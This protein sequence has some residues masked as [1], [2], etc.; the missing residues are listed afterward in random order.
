MAVPRWS[1]SPVGNGTWVTSGPATDLFLLAKPEKPASLRGAAGRGAFSAS[2]SGGKRDLYPQSRT[3]RT[4]SAH[5][6]G[7]AAGLCPGGATRM[8]VGRGS[9]HFFAGW[10]RKCASWGI[11]AARI[12]ARL[13]LRNGGGRGLRRWSG[14]PPAAARLRWSREAAAKPRSAVSVRGRLVS[15][16]LL[17]VGSLALHPLRRDI[18]FLRVFF[19]MVSD[20]NVNAWGA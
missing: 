1:P 15:Q 18:V 17:L 7:R 6:E 2:A 11:S 14:R 19:A 4:A 8:C 20:L 16:T 13:L 3:P 9:V 5:W 12:V 10:T